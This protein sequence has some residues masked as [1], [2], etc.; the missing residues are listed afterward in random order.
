MKLLWLDME[1]TGLDVN[2]ERIIEVAA[3]V[4]DEKWQELDSYHSIVYQDQ[5]FLDAMDDWNQK[6][7]G[8]SGLK[9]AVKEGKKEDLVEEELLQWIAKHWKSKEMPMLAGNSI[10]QDRK[11][12][13]AYWH[14]LE[15]RLHYRMLDVSSYKIVIELIHGIKFKK[16]DA[17]RALDDIRESIAE[18][19]FYL[20]YL[21]I[22]E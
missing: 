17:H 2:K 1:M 16:Q 9:A 8:A 12:I 3:I 6:Q 5:K 11:F 13:H 20:Q 14:K 15:E 10:H 4:T 18:L 22:P 19:K 21:K 7:H